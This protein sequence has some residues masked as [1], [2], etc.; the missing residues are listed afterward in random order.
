ML[1]HC[2]P[3]GG[4]A[5]GNVCFHRI[6]FYVNITIGKVIKFLRTTEKLNR[7]Y[8]IQRSVLFCIL[9]VIVLLADNYQ[10]QISHRVNSGIRC[11]K[12]L[13]TA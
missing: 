4:N 8:L 5:F 9:I 7:Y 1:L 12:L 10:Y 6:L 2:F 13:H 3:Q 11:L